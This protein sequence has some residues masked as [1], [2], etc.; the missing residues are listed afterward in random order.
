MDAGGV[1]DP[2]QGITQFVVGTGGADL[3]T[4][5]GKLANNS[6]VIITGVYGVLKLSLRPYGYDWEFIPE[7]GKT[8][9]DGGSEACH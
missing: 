3:R 9:G 5:P 1:L 4:P 2:A 6:Q 8:E 7:P